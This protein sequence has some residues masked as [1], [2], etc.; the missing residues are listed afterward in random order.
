MMTNKMPKCPSCGASLGEDSLSGLC[1]ACVLRAG[2]APDTRPSE[3][4]LD[5]RT[6]AEAAADPAAPPPRHGE[7]L[8]RYRILRRLGHGGMGVVYE[9]EEAD[10]GRRVA[11]KVLRQQLNSPQDRARFLREGRLAASINHP[12]CVY[13]FGTEEIEGTPT[14]AMEYLQGVTLAQLLKNE[15]PLPV[16]KAVDAMLQV[17]EGLEAAQ[18]VGI[19]HRDIK[20]SNCFVGS[21]GEVKIGDF[22][23]SISTLPRAEAE[24]TEVGTL[25]GTPAFCS[26]EQLRGEELGMRSDMYAVG[27]TLYQLLT[28]RLPF[29]GKS[30]PQLIANTLEKRAPSVRQQRKDIPQ[31]VDRA[32]RRCLEKQPG[33]RFRTYADLRR[34]L[35]PYS[36][37]APRPAT[38]GLRFLAGMIDMSIIGIVSQLVAILVLD[39]PMAILEYMMDDLGR[40]WR[41]I[42]PGFVAAILYDALP[43]WR[44]GAT[45]GKAICRLRVVRL[46]RR[47]PLLG[48]A[49]ARAVFFKVIPVLPFW[50]TA[51]FRPDWLV[52]PSAA[53]YLLSASYYLLLGLLFSTA[54]RRNG[55]ASV[56]DLLTRTRIVSRAAM[57]AP[58]DRPVAVEAPATAPSGPQIGPYHVLETLA[59]GP[60]GTWVEAYDL[61]LLRRVLVHS[62]TPGTPPLPTPVRSLAR[63]G[64]LRW[65]TGRREESE[66]W[67]A[68]EGVGGRALLSLVD[69]PQPWS[70]VRHWLSDLAVELQA[71]EQEGAPFSPLSLDRV[72]ITESGRAKLFDLPVP[73]W[74]KAEENGASSSA[75]PDAGTFLGRVAA[76]ALLGR[77]CPLEEGTV[78]IPLPLHA[79]EALALLGSGASLNRVAP[80]LRALLHRPA[81]VSRR[82]RWAVVG[83]CIFLPV[84]ATVGMALGG[85]MLSEWRQ[86]RPELLQIQQ[87]LQF[88]QAAKLP[89]VPEGS[90][91]GDRDIG[92]YL[93]SQFGDF[94]A[95][96]PAWTNGMAR[97]LVAGEMRAFAEES[98]SKYASVPEAEV[99]GVIQSLDPIVGAQRDL[100]MP[101]P[102]Q[103]A[104]TVFF[105]SITVYVGLP[106]MLAALLFRGGLVLLATG[107]TFVRR[108][109]LRA[110]RLRLFWR[111]LV[112]WVP[113]LFAGGCGIVVV[114][115]R[116]H[117]VALVGMA[118]VAVLTLW[119]LLLPT[120]AI[121]DRLAGTWP[122]PR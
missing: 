52:S 11:L 64:R 44:W 19:L 53:N 16:A 57:T 82:R 66:N 12:H 40:A 79:R 46:D 65:L 61:R 102:S 41:I 67:D 104:G 80:M 34:V 106:A 92:I 93:A 32:I 103:L 72:W 78:S 89:F 101:P 51:P 38:L 22:G 88:R 9:A 114:H 56:H 96:D 121:P 50:L 4:S 60:A 54:R 43:E 85:S 59:E 18:T 24:I 81:E 95:S 83:G 29:E 76:C 10:S 30:M 117:V 15:G 107:V 98:I 68:F 28:G 116:P 6:L 48:Q 86:E 110:S 7:Q 109:G 100:S 45:P 20:P 84:L 37:A 112:A 87:I 35:E 63:V 14:I 58:R 108:D 5:T 119:S 2:L 113:V 1:P 3:A 70:Q 27:V 74:D 115:D 25:V 90:L 13:V 26:P 118:T 91:P 49:L 94:I 122:V 69:K 111:A 31:A 55:F 17:I 62:V 47:Y 39:H 8:G 97:I 42:L 99:A 75:S 33:D 73:G 36:S 21:D 71:A 77:P 105:S 120:R 23:L